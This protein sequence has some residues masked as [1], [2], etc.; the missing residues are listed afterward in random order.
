MPDPTFDTVEESGG[1]IVRNESQNALVSELVGALDDASVKG[2]V[3]KAMCARWISTSVNGEDY[4]ETLHSPGVRETL[5]ILQHNEA[6]ANKMVASA[7]GTADKVGNFDRGKTNM[8]L[9]EA[10]V[11]TMLG[12]QA[13]VHLAMAEKAAADLKDNWASK[14]IKDN[15]SLN[16]PALSDVKPE[17]LVNKLTEGTG[18]YL[19]GIEGAGGGHA[20][21]L[22]NMPGVGVQY[23]DPNLGEVIF[24]DPA[25]FKTWMTTHLSNYGNVVGN[26]TSSKLTFVERK[27]APDRTDCQQWV[28]DNAGA[29]RGPVPPVHWPVWESAKAKQDERD[30]QEQARRQAHL[31]SLQAKFGNGANNAAPT[32]RKANRAGMMLTATAVA[33]MGVNGAGGP[34]GNPT[35]NAV[36]NPNP[37]PNPQPNANPDAGDG[38]ASKADKKSWRRGGFYPQ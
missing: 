38:G 11:K 12:Q 19:F 25:K 31:Q 15:T 34:G 9:M 10:K 14:Y 8:A 5:R 35:V 30:R 6:A 27:S 28:V 20:M 17:E 36:P 1:E 24:T 2:G 18:Y 4:W 22:Y 33:G 3:C 32:G 29:Q 16:A 7:L 21:A 37:N 23:F 13:P 26:I